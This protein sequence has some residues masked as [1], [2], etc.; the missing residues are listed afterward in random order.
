V[1]DI[2]LTFEEKTTLENSNL[3]PME[4]IETNGPK[5]SVVLSIDALQNTMIHCTNQ[6]NAAA[7]LRQMID[8][9]ASETRKPRW[10]FSIPQGDVLAT[11]LEQIGWFAKGVHLFEGSLKNNILLGIK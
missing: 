3:F 10:N 9:T 4:L 8:P 1:Q 6:R 2:P 11:Q 7:F 5:A